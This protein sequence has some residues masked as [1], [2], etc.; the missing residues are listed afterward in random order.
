MV[1][2]LT[3]KIVDFFLAKKVKASPNINP[4]TSGK[5]AINQ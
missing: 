1:K 3:K 2:G 4:L 5:A